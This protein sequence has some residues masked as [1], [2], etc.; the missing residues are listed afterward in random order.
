MNSWRSGWCPDWGPRQGQA[1]QIHIYFPRMSP[2]MDR[3]WKKGTFPHLSSNTSPKVMLSAG[4]HIL[5]LREQYIQFSSY[6]FFLAESLPGCNSLH[7]AFSCLLQ[8]LHSFP[9]ITGGKML[10]A[11]SPE[12]FHR[13]CCFIPGANM[14]SDLYLCRRC[15]W[16]FFLEVCGR[17]GFAVWW[18]A[19]LEKGC[20]AGHW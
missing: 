17:E 13:S 12:I 20:K 2:F 10:S 14:R 9:G 3:K 6:P 7:E 16:H 4:V 8:H 5:C 15:V 1:S 19:P 18:T 11:N